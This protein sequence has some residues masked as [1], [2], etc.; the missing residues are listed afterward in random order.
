MPAGRRDIPPQSNPRYVR[1]PDEAY[2]LDEDPTFRQHQAANDVITRRLV[3]RLTGR[4]P[5]EQTHYGSKPSRQYFAGVLASQYKYREALAQDEA[6]QDIAEDVAPFR[7]G[8]TFRVPTNIDEDA[9]VELTPSANVYYRRFPEVDEQRE[10]GGERHLHRTPT[11]ERGGPQSSRHQPDVP[12]EA[13]DGGRDLRSDGGDGESDD[14]EEEAVV[15]LLP[16]YERIELDL[17][18]HCGDELVLT[19]SDLHSLADKPGPK[20]VSLS[21]AF[22]DAEETVRDDPLAFRELPSDTS[23]RD[24]R[25]IPVE[26]LEDESAFRGWIGET[27]SSDVVDPLWEG[28][29]RV[30]VREESRDEGEDRFVIEATFVNTHGSDYPDAGDY[31]YKMWRA[32]LFDVGIDASVD[33]PNI[34]PFQLDEIRDEYQYDGR[35]YAV[36]ENCAAEPIYPP[37]ERNPLADPDPVGVRT[38]TLPVY[39][40]SKYLP[41]EPIPLQFDV[42]ANNASLSGDDLPTHVLEDLPEQVNGTDEIDVDDLL[43]ILQKEMERAEGHYLDVGDDV[44][45]DKS[46]EAERRFEEAIS[47]FRDERRR[48][49]QGRKLIRDDDRVREAFTLLNETFIEMGDFPGWRLF[50]LVFI[51]MSIPDIVAQADPDREVTNR[52]D[53]AD[54]IYYPTGGGKTEAYL[55]LVTFTAFHDRLRGKEYGTTALTKFPL[56][57]LSLEQLQRAAEVLGHA[58]LVR[59]EGGLEGDP[60]S[61][62][63]FVGKD[64]VPNKLMDERRYDR[65]DR[66]QEAKDDPPEDQDHEFLILSECPFCGNESVEIDGDHERA[67]IDHVC[68]H[69]EC[70]WVTLHDGEE[71]L[72][73]YVTDREVY[74]HAPTFVVSTIDKISIVGMQRRFRTLLGHI[75][76]RCPHHGFTG[77]EDCLVDDYDYPSNHTCDNED[78]VEV[79]SVDPPSLIIQDELHLLR[80]EFGSFDSHYETLLQTL[81]EEFG[82]GWQMK[83]V[84]ATATIKGAER[85]VE[86]LY[87]REHNTFPAQGPRLKQ[88]FYAYAHPRKVGRN[89]IGGIPRNVSRT[90]AI[91]RIHEE[92]ARI[93]QEF[94]E[95]PAELDAAIADREPNEGEYDNDELDFSSGEDERKD[96]LIDVLDD[97]EVQVSYHYAKDNTQ[98]MKR[99]VR[100][101]INRNLA[102]AD[103]NYHTLRPV[104]MTGETPLSLVRTYKDEIEADPEDREEPIHVVIAT[105]MISHGIDIERFNFIAF[106]GTPRSTAEYIQSY[107]R[108]G[109]EHPGSV[110][111]SFHP[112][113]VKDQSHYHQFHHHH[114][115]EDLLVEATPLERWAKYGIEQTFSGL[116][117][118]LFLQLFDGEYG[119]ELSERLY[120][121]EGLQEAIHRDEIDVDRQRVENLLARAYDVHDAS[122]SDADAASIYSERLEK[123]FDDLW[124]ALIDAEPDDD[125]TFLPHVFGTLTDENDEPLV[126]AREPMT[127]LRDIDEQIPIEP[128]TNTAKAINLFTNQ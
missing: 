19:G 113:Q 39:E 34:T 100:T 51:V 107:S 119:G 77:E 102:T 67:R 59:R 27:Y 116:F 87:R 80:E 79:D 50:Q 5:N 17:K 55:G 24:G 75:E 101:M 18:E 109:R 85:Q 8:V 48:F 94:Q 72:P 46:D 76:A 58:E 99:S 54:V 106:H 69:S 70:P 30:Q 83:V 9:T 37:E 114:E 36:G 127:N 112:M 122:P 7:I 128:D 28:D 120:D 12:Q 38:V 103:G 29:L 25:E 123:M 118:A 108:V 35:M 104:L 73:V 15:D 78:L 91:N 65:V 71:P 11:Y 86:A 110:Y 16:V 14:G 23:E 20:V 90:F 53:T 126:G 111:M 13:T 95:N 84:A 63:Y 81:A 31:E 92:Q 44:L 88:S 74:R 61:V 68:T 33:G 6:F 4:G 56:R 124:P 32:F 98:L 89:M 41:R 57:F 21:S 3:R 115:Y 121:W 40:Q 52:L 43:L 93:V 2:E 1:P 10:R 64:N 22:T 47:S 82:D 42:L 66:I 45:S 105:S 49:E 96:E 60:F 97:Y 26:L 125:N 62:G 117:C